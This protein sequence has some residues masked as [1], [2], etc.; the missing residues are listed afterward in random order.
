M[1]CEGC[2]AAVQFRQQRMDGEK[3]AVWSIYV[4]DIHIDLNPR[5][6]AVLPFKV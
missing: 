3:V 1:G 5:S 6:I 2:V 4:A